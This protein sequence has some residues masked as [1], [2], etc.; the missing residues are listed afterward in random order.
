MRHFG[1]QRRTHF[2]PIRK[3]AFNADRIDDSTRE[4]MRAD[5]RTFFQHANRDILAF[6]GSQLLQAN[7]GGQTGG[8]TTDNHNIIFHAFAFFRRKGPALTRIDLVNRQ[9]AHFELRH[10]CLYLG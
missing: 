9:I 8:A 4:D 2:F 3:Q 7:G 5:F 1:F 6:F 10:W